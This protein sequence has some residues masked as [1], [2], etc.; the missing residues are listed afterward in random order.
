MSSRGRFCWLKYRLWDSNVQYIEAESNWVTTWAAGSRYR[1]HSLHTG[2]QR[3]WVERLEGGS[4]NPFPYRGYLGPRIYEWWYINA[5][6]IESMPQGPDKR[7][8]NDGN[9]GLFARAVDLMAS[10]ANNSVRCL[11]AFN[12]PRTVPHLKLRPIMYMESFYRNTQQIALK[13]YKWLIGSP[14][15]PWRGSRSDPAYSMNQ[16]RPYHCDIPVAALG[17]MQCP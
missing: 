16:Q 7:C 4:M 12:I 15:S 9:H 8:P 14:S 1:Y 10:W 13:H 17:T 2:V 5:P 11:R 3:R 6:F